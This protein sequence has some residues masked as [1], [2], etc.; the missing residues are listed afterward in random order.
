MREAGLR[1][2][3]RHGDEIDDGLWP[4]IHRHYRSTFER[5]GGVA[6]FSEEF[7][8]CVVPR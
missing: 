7:F 4:A 1:I 5:L 6:A 2:E 8:R 3:V